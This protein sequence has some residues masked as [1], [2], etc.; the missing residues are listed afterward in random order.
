MK[1]MDFLTLLG[2]LDEGA[3][4]DTAPVMKQ[5]ARK[6]KKRRALWVAAAAC[7]CACLLGFSAWFFLPPN[8]VMNDSSII[9]VIRVEDQLFCY[10]VIRTKAMSRFELLLLP[11]ERGEVLA[12]HGDSTFYR[13]AGE[14]DLEYIF[15]IDGDGKQRLLRF[16]DYV[17]TAG[18]DMTTS[19]WYESGWLDDEDIA[20][21]QGGG[22]GTM[23]EILKIVYGVDSAEDIR[24]IR[25][26]KYGDEDSVSRRVRIKTV[27]I[28][29][30][31]TVARIYGMLASMTSMAYGQEWHSGSASARDEAYLKGEK[32]LSVQVDREITVTL[33]SGRELTFYYYP[34]T[35]FVRRNRPE[36]YTVL[37]EADNEWLIALAE[38][39]ME[40]KDWGTEKDYEY[41]GEGCETATT[42]IIPEPQAP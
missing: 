37:S 31:E 34:V 39:D 42:P 16:D 32:P 1:A 17:N 38:I 26:S 13:A 36:F 41:G 12:V 15:Q 2:D 18:V 6:Q 14:E 19:Y 40:W 21:L 24:S 28:T 10:K 35:G 27:R 29:D 25:F 7:F 20:A 11:E 22:D 33:T 9:T 23:G 4:A 8:V 3:V 30:R 5:K